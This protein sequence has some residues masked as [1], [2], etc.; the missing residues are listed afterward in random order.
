MKQY[1]IIH[2]L[3]LFILAAASAN[4]QDTIPKT[5]P[6]AIPQN[7]GF[8]V[9][10]K[11]NGDLVYGLVKEVDALT[12]KYKRTDIPDGPLY[13]INRNE[14]YA[15]SYRN[16][17]KDILSTPAF[18]GYYNRDTLI[19]DSVKVKPVMPTIRASLFSRSKV[20]VGLG[21][22]R[23]FS[24]VEDA[25]SYSTSMSFPFLHIG[26]EMYK[27]NFLRVGLLMSSGSHKFSR[28]EFNA[29]DNETRDIQLNES[30]FAL[31]L[32]GKYTVEGFHHGSGHML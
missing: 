24:K 26:Y 27:N 28:Q 7:A 4:A 19:R 2:F 15:I 11:K 17:V 29:Y 23:G 10:I 3:F 9:I 20:L 13:T 21:F 32:Y 25:N 16:Q 12:I 18:P 14:V 6:Y 5:N 31:H 22:I 1:Y 8:D 30:I